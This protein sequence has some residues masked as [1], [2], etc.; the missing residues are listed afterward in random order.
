MEG[1]AQAINAMTLKKIAIS[2]ALALA[3]GFEIICPG[4]GEDPHIERDVI[5]EPEALREQTDELRPV[6]TGPE[7]PWLIGYTLRVISP[8]ELKGW[9]MNTQ[10]TTSA[11]LVTVGRTQTNGEVRFNDPIVIRNAHV[12][13]EIEG[14]EVTKRVYLNEDYSITL[15][16]R[17]A[18]EQIQ[19]FLA[20]RDVTTQ[21]LYKEGREKEKPPDFLTILSNFAPVNSDADG[22]TDMPT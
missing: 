12:P 15:L 14:Y 4:G 11:G 18:A 16:N 7:N 3:L 17:K 13:K 5:L 21:L 19:M 8:A 2:V 10:S 22:V 20:K 9:W 6:Y 1:Q